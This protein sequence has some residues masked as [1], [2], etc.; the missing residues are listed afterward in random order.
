MDA[1]GQPSGAAQRWRQRRRMRSWWRHE[2][3]SIAAAVATLHHSAQRGGGVV[4]RPTGTEDS[5]NREEVEHATHFGPRAQM[6]PPPG[7]RPGILAEPGPQTSDRSRQHSLEK[8]SRPSA[9]PHWLGRLE[10]QCLSFLKARLLRGWTR[11]GRG[12]SSGGRRSRRGTTGRRGER[13]RG[14]RRNFLA[15]ASLVAALVVDG[16]GT[17]LAGFLVSRRVPVDFRQA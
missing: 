15:V 3:A 5:G 17:L 1:S 14:R 7:E 13:K 6:T 16:M 9:C 2:Q 8:T 11:A 4:R 10:R 12:P